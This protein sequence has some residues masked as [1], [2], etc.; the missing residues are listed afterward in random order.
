[1]KVIIDRDIEKLVQY[2]VERGRYDSADQLVRDALLAFLKTD[3]KLHARIR[4]LQKEIDLGL[5]DIKHGKVAKFD[6]K[7]IK[8]SARRRL[9]SRE[10]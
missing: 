6:P 3:P 8:R 1:M 5:H 7:A 9:S 2:T 4:S 10:T